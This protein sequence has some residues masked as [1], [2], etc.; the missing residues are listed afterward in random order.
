MTLLVLLLVGRALYV[1]PLALLHNVWSPEQ[2]SARDIVVVWCAVFSPCSVGRSCTLQ[3]SRPG[4][5]T[6]PATDGPAISKEERCGAPI[7]NG[8]TKTPGSTS[9]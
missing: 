5:R 7:C 8:N 6:Q 4:N 1:V 3:G 9:A 2:L